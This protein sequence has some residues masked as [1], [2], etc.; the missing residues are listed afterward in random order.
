MDRSYT[1]YTTRRARSL[2]RIPPTQL[3]E[4]SYT[5]YK[6]SYPRPPRCLIFSPRDARERGK[7][8]GSPAC[9]LC[10]LCLNNPPTA[11]VGF[12][13]FSHCLGSGWMVQAQPTQ[14]APSSLSQIPP[15][16]VGWIVQAQPTQRAPSSLSQIPP[17]EVG[18]W[19][20]LNLHKGRLLP[21]PK[22]PTRQ[23]VDRSSAALVAA[24]PSTCP[25]G[26]ED[27]GGRR[28]SM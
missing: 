7:G 21:F 18:G 8:N 4:R 1:A 26:E 28:L 6:Q 15:T 23:W 2:P 9:A 12:S 17:T 22:S 20:K 14:R 24:S 10:R 27:E 16:A 13:E 19:F 11:L 25:R 5:A 3:V